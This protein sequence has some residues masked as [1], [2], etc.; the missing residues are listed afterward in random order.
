[1]TVANGDILDVRGT[2]EHPLACQGQPLA[3]QGQPLACPEGFTGV[4]N[5]LRRLEAPERLNGPLR[6][7]AARVGGFQPMSWGAAAALVSRIFTAYQPGE[8]AFVLGDFPDHLS[9][10]V[11]Q[12]AGVLG[13]ST[14]LRFT[15]SSLLDGRVTLQDASR[16]LFGLPR[17]PYFDVT[18]SS[19]VFSFGLSGQEPWLTR[20]AGSSGRPVGQSWVHF[21]PT[22]PAWIGSEDEWVPIRPGSDAMLAQGLGGLIAKLKA[23]AS[24]VQPLPSEVEAASQASG[25]P[26]DEMIRLAPRFAEA[27]SALALPGADCLGASGGLAAA[28]AVLA[29]NGISGRLGHPGGLYLTPETPLFPDLNGRTATLAEVQALIQRME[30]GQVKALFV[31]GVDLVADLP[32]GLDV[33]RALQ[34]VEHIIL[35]NS[36]INET[37][38]LADVLLPDHLP[39]ESW[40]YQRLSPAVDRALVSAIQPA[41]APRY[42]TR[43]TAD[44]LLEAA[45]HAGGELLARLPYRNERDLLRQA[46][47]R[48]PWGTD[49]S[50]P[51]AHWL[52][53]GG[54]WPLQPNLLPPVSLRPPEHWLRH[55]QAPWPLD[56]AGQ[57]FYLHF[58][59]P[60]SDR[61]SQTAWS[62]ELPQV[63]MHPDAARRLSL[64]PGDVVR[65]A[66]ASV[67]IEAQV[68]E[69]AD[70]R[71]DMLV[72]PLDPSQSGRSNPLSLVCGEQNES[73]DLAFQSGR[74]R[75]SAS[76]RS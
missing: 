51:W 38:P 50:D 65:L 59:W 27:P 62:G 55:T 61:A 10:L 9:D 42:F 56:P 24:I 44:L 73:G 47:L 58:A 4:E 45:H 71:L 39:L 41:F 18:H 23:G 43:S 21:S 16:M 1:L 15:R 37:T 53:Q 35:F 2:P 69:R 49:I 14:V 74:V 54:W 40:G 13:G 29:L 64:Q 32:A 26:V 70:L 11:H 28:Q 68:A 30:I 3:C 76:S 5:I 63:V 66:T 72:L 36:L 8:I 31:H 67:E 25:I 57:E 17:L 22:C 46:V 34:Q 33:E 7:S 19:L 75:S 52:A 48:L 12:L 60:A 6:R 20:F